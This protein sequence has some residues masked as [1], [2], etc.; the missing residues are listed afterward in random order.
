MSESTEKKTSSRPTQ[1]LGHLVNPDWWLKMAAEKLLQRM[2]ERND[3]SEQ[4]R[5]LFFRVIAIYDKREQ[6]LRRWEVERRP[7][8][9]EI[10][11]KDVYLCE[12]ETCY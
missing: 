7:N 8:R 10:L 5:I 1:A 2:Y 9:I 11:E 6:Y 12:V 4:N 3:L